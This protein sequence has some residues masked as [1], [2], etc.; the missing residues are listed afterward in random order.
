MSAPCSIDDSQ[1]CSH[2]HPHTHGGVRVGE[3]R[4]PRHDYGTAAR[5]RIR[6]VLSLFKQSVPWSDQGHVRASTPKTDTGGPG[7][8]ASHSMRERV[9][10]PTRTVLGFHGHQATADGVDSRCCDH[11]HH[12]THIHMPQGTSSHVP[13][14][15]SSGKREGQS[16]QRQRCGMDMGERVT[17][18][19]GPQHTTAATATPE[20]QLRCC[21]LYQTCV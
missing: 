20:M 11:R 13:C 16:Q 14:G 7:A 1:H 6:C 2:G 12:H 17:R 10:K 5:R 8:R 3:R 9:S 19:R 18:G 21:I 15:L 4:L